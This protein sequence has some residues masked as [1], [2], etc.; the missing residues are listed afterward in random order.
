[1]IF[2]WSTRSY[3]SWNYTGHARI[4]FPLRKFEIDIRTKYLFRLHT[5][6]FKYSSIYNPKNRQLTIRREP[7]SVDADDRYVF[8]MK[9]YHNQT[10]LIHLQVINNHYEIIGNPSNEN[11][12]WQFHGYFH[13]DP[14]NGS[15][16]LSNSDW[17]LSSKF[18]FNSSL[19][20]STGQYVQFISTLDHQIA[21]EIQLKSHLHFVFQYSGLRSLIALKCFHNSSNIDLYFSLKSINETMFNLDFQFNNQINQSWILELSDKRFYLSNHNS[22]FIFNGS[23][24]DFSFEHVIDNQKNQF[25]INEN[26]I[27]FLTNETH[28]ILSNLSSDTSKYVYLH[29]QPSKQN[30]TINY[31]KTGRFFMENFNIQTPIYDINAIYYPNDDENRYVK[32]LFEFLPLQM[33]SFS[34][35]RG[36]TFR[37]GYETKQKQCILTG[38]LAFGLED[39]D[40]K[41]ILIMNE[42][43]KF[44]YGIERHEKIYIK[45]NIK[46]NLKQKSLQGQMNIQDPNEI[47]SIPI[48]STINA[49]LK[50]MIFITDIRTIYSSSEKPIL[51]QLNIDQRLLTQQYISVKLIHESSKTNLSFIIDHYPQRKFLIRLKPNHSPDE[52]TLVHLYANTTESQLKLLFILANE[53]HLNLT[54]PKSYPETGLLHSSLFIENEEFFDGRLD[55]TALKIRTKEYLLNISLNEI[56]LQKRFD[57]KM[58]LASI[59]ARWIERNSSTALIHIFSQANFQRV[60]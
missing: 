31:Y 46:I 12:Y 2:E 57:R 47:I 19:Y 8:K 7:I 41:D 54:L 6:T 33:S 37:I 27:G 53:I 45:W 34:L 39:I 51:V 42:R 14:F 3:L 30:L 59:V 4:L 21:L 25:F 10:F 56:I 1:M 28:F 16:I 5:S 58:I 60:R 11:F 50:D 44:H 17:L 52:K 40:R 26:S 43:W 48:Y 23:L 9:F 15:L 49:Y 29:H 38:N 35:V 24:Q 32:V 20:I 18:D 22:E 55:E 36:R 13:K